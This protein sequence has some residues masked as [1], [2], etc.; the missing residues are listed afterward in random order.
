MK[1]IA[2]LAVPAMTYIRSFFVES[3][4]S[5]LMVAYAIRQLNPKQISAAMIGL[6]ISSEFLMNFSGELLRSR[7]IS[8]RDYGQVAIENAM[9]C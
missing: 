5:A 3:C 1:R 4:E 8:S 7:G 6:L 9:R 2:K